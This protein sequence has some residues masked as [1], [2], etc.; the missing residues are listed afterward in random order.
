MGSLISFLIEAADRFDV[1]GRAYIG[2]PRKYYFTDLGLWNAVLNYRQFE[3][4]HSLE[5]IIYNELLIRGLRVDVGVVPIAERNE[6]G[7]VIRKQLEIDFVCNKNGKLYYIQSA[8]SIPDEKKRAQETRPF[9]KTSDSFKKI[10]VTNDMTP[11]YYDENGIY[12]V[13]IVDF[14]LDKESLDK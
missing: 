9:L 4:T 2:T 3:P 11:A 1:K 6:K 14:L 13:N 10:I 7:S 5:N 12:T 8:Y